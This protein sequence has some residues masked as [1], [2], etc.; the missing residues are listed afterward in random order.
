MLYI[1]KL[2]FL[3][4]TFRRL[5]AVWTEE[6]EQQRIAMIINNDKRAFEQEMRSQQRDHDSI[7]KTRRKEEAHSD[8]MPNNEPE[9]V[10]ESHWC[11]HCVSPLKRMSSDMKKT[12]QRFLLLRRTSYNQVNGRRRIQ[13]KVGLFNL[14]VATDEC[15]NAKNFSRLQRQICRH[16][17]CTTISLVD[18]NEGTSF[19][20][21][22]CAENFGA[23]DAYF[24]AKHGDRSC[25]TLHDHLDMKECLCSD[26]RYCLSGHSRRRASSFPA[27]SFSFVLLS[28]LYLSI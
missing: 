10:Y 14:D 25:T 11:Y 21:R 12:I 4:I 18:H 19:V 24:L 22:G 20:I 17:Y 8:I 7:T 28:A 1:T 13:V 27:P 15:I 9:K 2:L 3:L 23:I 16:P 6:D 5:S 26:R